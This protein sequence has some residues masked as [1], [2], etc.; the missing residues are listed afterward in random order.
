L[1]HASP[2]VELFTFKNLKSQSD[3]AHFI[4]GSSVVGNLS[5]AIGDDPAN[6]KENRNK[7]ASALS[8]SPER[9]VFCKQ[10]HGN[11]V[12]LVTSEV[13]ANRTA[14]G[15]IAQECDAMITKEKNVMLCILVADCVPILF[16]DPVVSAIGVAHAGWR[17]SAKK[18]AVATVEKMRSS[19]GGKSEDLVVAMG[20]AIG[21]DDFEVGPEVVKALSA[22]ID[23]PEA[24]IRPG[25]GDRTYVDLWEV[26]RQQ[27]ESAG[28]EQRHIEVMRTSTFSN[29]E[30]FFSARRVK[31][32]GRFGGGLMLTP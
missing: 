1:I 31:N 24:A 23:A 6:V 32:C 14:D 30:L 17:G 26:N 10:V 18:I 8:L 5:F 11:E 13:I 12:A 21:S 25:K 3:I 20:P 9:F 15:Q 28:V 4:S 27:L 22:T 2:T 7:L 16:Y 29:P 19:F